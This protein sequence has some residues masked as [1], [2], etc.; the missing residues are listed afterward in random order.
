MRGS[1]DSNYLKGL[2]LS[3]CLDFILLENGWV[4]LLDVKHE[5]AEGTVDVL[6]AALKGGVVGRVAHVDR[7]GRLAR[8]HV[9]RRVQRVHLEVTGDHQ[10]GVRRLRVDEAASL[11]ERAA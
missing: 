6:A 5:I 3:L 11:R 1:R 7:D 8:G 4:C 2:S 10:V 9:V